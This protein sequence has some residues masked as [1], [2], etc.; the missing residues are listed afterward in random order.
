MS[1][2]Q[3]MKLFL[4]RSRVYKSVNDKL[5]L[6]NNNKP[7]YSSKLE[8]SKEFK[9]S[10]KTI[11]KYLDSDKEYKGLYFYSVEALP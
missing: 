7:T 4:E 10:T 9:M 6:L 2:K 3:L 11:S 5:I 1:K 8:A